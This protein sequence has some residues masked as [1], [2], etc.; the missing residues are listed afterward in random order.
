MLVWDGRDIQTPPI[1]IEVNL[2]KG[3]CHI[4]QVYKSNFG[5][6]FFRAKNNIYRRLADETTLE[7]TILVGKVQIADHHTVVTHMNP[8]EKTCA[9][10]EIFQLFVKIL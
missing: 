4:W 10:A 1:K 8:D 3:Q 5:S 7:S 6:F 2:T 9:F